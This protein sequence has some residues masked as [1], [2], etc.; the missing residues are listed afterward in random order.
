MMAAT[1]LPSE[2]MVSA[3]ASVVTTN[4]A[5][6]SKGSRRK[7]VFNFLTMSKDSNSG[8]SGPARPF[9]RNRAIIQLPGEAVLPD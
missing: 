9:S 1:G 6:R 8:C 2:T 4:K 3:P 5:A 7:G